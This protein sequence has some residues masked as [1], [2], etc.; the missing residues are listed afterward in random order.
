MIEEGKKEL[1]YTKEVSPGKLYEE[2]YASAP[3]LAPELDSAGEVVVYVR[4]FTNG[5][6]L[7]LWVPEEY[8]E[9]FF[10]RIVEKH[11]IETEIKEGDE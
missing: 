4:I 3:E 5:D 1:V 2:I 11:L 6:T 8:D 10:N 7:K 9:A